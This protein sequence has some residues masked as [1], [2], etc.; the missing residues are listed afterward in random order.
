MGVSSFGL[1][2]LQKMFM[3]GRLVEILGFPLLDDN[4]LLG[5][6][7][8]ASPEAVTIP[9]INEACLSFDDLKG[10]F[11]TLGDTEATAITSLFIDFNDFPYGH[12]HFLLPL[13][14][15]E[16]NYFTEASLTKIK[17]GR[18]FIFR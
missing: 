12:F 17:N 4:G 7:T 10:P 9:A 3:D 18:M 15:K 1:P 6:F 2:H 14:I 8:Q 11:G 13:F 5:T 16:Y